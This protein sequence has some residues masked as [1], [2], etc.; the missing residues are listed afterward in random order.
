MFSTH[1]TWNKVQPLH[2]QW[3][4]TK[5]KRHHTLTNVPS[6]T[7]QCSGGRCASTKL[8]WCQSHR[9]EDS[10]QNWTKTS[11][12]W[13]LFLTGS[14]YVR[15][16]FT[17]FSTFWD[18]ANLNRLSRTRS[19]HLGLNSRA[20]GFDWQKGLRTKVRLTC[21]FWCSG[22]C[23]RRRLWPWRR[24]VSGSCR[25]RWTSAPASAPPRPGSWG[26]AAPSLWNDGKPD[27]DGQQCWN[28]AR[29]NLPIL[30]KTHSLDQETSL[31]FHFWQKFGKYEYELVRSFLGV[32]NVATRDVFLWFPATSSK[33][34]SAKK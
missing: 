33:L 15:V 30:S 1:Q 17:L 34:S 21:R 5:L 16:Y 29:S 18:C 2:V 24:A 13:K 8:K 31:R 25:P 14:I 19:T 23:W 12:G 6:P 27:D 26:R 22:P 9:V 32:Y 3:S 4:S 7:F 11:F 10:T 28:P 20:F